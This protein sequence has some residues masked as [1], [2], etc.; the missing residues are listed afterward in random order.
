MADE[1]LPLE[2][3]QDPRAVHHVGLPG[4]D[5][6]D[7]ERHLVRDVLAVGVHGHHDGRVEVKHDVVADPQGQPASSPDGEPGHQGPGGASHVG[8]LVLRSVI[9]DQRHHRISLHLAGHGVDDRAHVARLVVG[10][11]D[12]HHPLPCRECVDLRSV[13]GLEREGL[14]QQPDAPRCPVDA[15]HV[16]EQ[17]EEHHDVGEQ[18]DADE[19][20]ARALLELEHVEHGVEHHGS[21]GQDQDHRGDQPRDDQA[22]P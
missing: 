9:D 16:P 6:L 8:G 2:L 10:G 11:Q 3:A 22:Q 20:P 13:E 17:E 12:H 1:A 18:Q 7:Q 5:G 19:A 14:H 15:G 4:Q 21:H